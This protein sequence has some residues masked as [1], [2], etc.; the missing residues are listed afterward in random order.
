MLCNVFV[1]D[2]LSILEIKI[3]FNLSAL[4]Y[5]QQSV[6]AANCDFCLFAVNLIVFSANLVGKSRKNQN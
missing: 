5:L 2:H 4:Y 3:I 1:L 6:I